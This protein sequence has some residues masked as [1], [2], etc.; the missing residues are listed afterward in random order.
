MRVGVHDLEFD[1]RLELERPRLLAFLTRTCGDGHDAEDVLQETLLRAHR[2]RHQLERNEQF[3]AWLYA[4][5]RHTCQRLHRRRSGAPKQLESLTELVANPTAPPEEW[6]LAYLGKPSDP[7]LERVRQEAREKL[8]AALAQVPEPF[9]KTL[10][11]GEIAELSVAE[12]ARVLGVKEATVKTRLHRGRLALRKAL[13]A[14]GAVPRGSLPSGHVCRALLEAK[15]E[16]MD[17]GV[18]FPYP[19]EALC[20]R[21]RAVF[22]GLDLNRVICR[23]LVHRGPLE[24]VAPK[25]G[26]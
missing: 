9:R 4:I 1:K 11:L 26:T 24:G 12:I 8:D 17:R 25:G 5:A 20:E 6:Q 7:E 18:P 16:A 14:P 13:Q 10:A 22:R 21:C 23:D 19:E 15:L 2:A 3:R